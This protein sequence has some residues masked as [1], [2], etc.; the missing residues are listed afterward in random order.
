MDTKV[1]SV[2]ETAVSRA[3]AKGF[4]STTYYSAVEE[5]VHKCVP[6]AMSV[7][8]VAVKLVDAPSFTVHDAKFFK[9]GVDKNSL[10]KTMM[11]KRFARLAEAVELKE[12]NVADVIPTRRIGAARSQAPRQT[13][14]TVR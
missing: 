2:I 12:V 6:E 4:R 1:Y 3:L 11:K 14:P 8:T 9:L 10:D 5:D 7:D 13:Y